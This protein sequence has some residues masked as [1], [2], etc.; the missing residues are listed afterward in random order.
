MPSMKKKADEAKMSKT[1]V[2]AQWIDEFVSGPMSGKQIEDAV[3]KFRKALIERALGGELK[4]HLGYASAAAKPEG[5]SNQ[6]NG[7][8]GKTVLSDGGPLRIDVPQDRQGSFEPVLSRCMRG[9]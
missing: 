5:V 3:L 8:S 2:P 7:S 6:R 9:A 1:S 4:H